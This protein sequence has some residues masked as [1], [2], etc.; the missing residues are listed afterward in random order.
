[1]LPSQ[2]SR[3]EAMEF[4]SIVV[5]LGSLDRRLLCLAL[6]GAV[7]LGT[8]AARLSQFWRLRK[9]PGPFGTGVSWLWHSCA[10]LSGNA[11]RWYGDVTE[12]HGSIARVAPNLLITSSPELWAHI[13]AVRSPYT[14]ASWYYHCVRF[15]PGKDNVFTDCDN[16]SHD[17]R[18]KKMAAGYSGKENPTL[19]A[20]IDTQ[21][22]ELVRLLRS[23][24]AAPAASHSVSQPIDLA[25][26]LQ[27]LTLDVISDVGFGQPFGDLKADADVNDYLKSMEDGLTICNTSWGLGISWLRDVPLLG[28]AISPSEKDERG[29][30]KMMAYAR[31]CVRER[32]L[33]PT[34][35]RSDMLSSFIRHGLKGDELFHEVFEQI[36]AG[37]DTT[38]ASLR[39]IMLYLMTHPRVYIKLQAEIDEV[40]RAGVAPAAPGIISDVAVKGLAYLG[41]VVREGLR[42]HPPVVNIFSKVVPKGGDVVDVDGKEHFLPGGTLIGYS[43]WSMHRNNRAVY[44]DDADVFRPERWLIGDDTPGGKEK[45]ARMIKTNDM[46][47]GYGRWHCVGRNV[48]WMEIHKTVF[49]LLRNFDFELAHPHESWT[50]HNIVGLFAISNMWVQVTER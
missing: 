36:L 50:I 37:S 46:I 42:V 9:F 49:E 27:Y 4:D 39:V 20:S 23:K 45:L 21:I 31:R 15:E 10:V 44:G 3:V 38:V 1:M 33:Q 22:L 26:K 41:A 12:K 29:F 34:D 47:F 40:V 24:Y 13:N 43:A 35:Q 19:E 17:A 11:H 30:G 14:R 2:S 28:K 8:V 25:A 6:V 16:N 18:R 48:A 7:L 5:S 32:M